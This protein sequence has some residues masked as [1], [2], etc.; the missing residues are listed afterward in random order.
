MTT[1]IKVRT[2][3]QIGRLV[4]FVLVGT[5]LTAVVE[6]PTWTLPLIVLDSPLTLRFSSPW[7]I[8]AVLAVLISA[9][10]DLML[11]LRPSRTEIEFLRAAPAWVLPALMAI[12]APVLIARLEPLTT[13]WLAVLAG[14]G[15]GVGLALLG[16]AYAAAPASGGRRIA[17]VGLTALAYATALVIFVAIDSAQV[18]TALSGTATFATSFLLATALLRWPTEPADRRWPYGLAIGLIVGLTTWGLNHVALD[19]LAGGSLLLL[20]FHVLTGITQQFLWKTLNRRA[21]IEFAVV[22]VVGLLL[23]G[24]LGRGI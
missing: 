7:L 18:R 6:L 5:A 11:R 23:I 10:T 9:G 8:A 13:R 14:S 2:G 24:V 22:T 17:R 21:L 1:E 4:S 15:L 19:G 12:V 3:L 16:E 20:V